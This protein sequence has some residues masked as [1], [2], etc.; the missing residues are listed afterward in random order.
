MQRRRRR[1][2]ECIFVAEL[3]LSDDLM[4]R[5]GLRPVTEAAMSSA[6]EGALRQC[7]P[8]VKSKYLELCKL[9]PP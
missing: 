9:S 4:F 5:F 1:K 3:I 8:T 6:G 7:V 2:I